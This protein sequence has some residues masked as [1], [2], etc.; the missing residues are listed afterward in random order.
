MLR[1]G[2]AGTKAPFSWQAWLIVG[3]ERKI[4][5]DTGFASVEKAR[6]WQIDGFRSVPQAIALL[7]LKP[8][9]ITD[10]VLT[11]AHWDHSGNL[12]PYERSRAWIQSQEYDWARSLTSAE[13]PSRSG[14]RLADVK[15]LERFDEAGRLR[16]VD[17]EAEVAPGVTLSRGGGHTRAIQWVTVRTGGPTGTVVLATDVAYVYES[18][19]RDMP[20]GATATPDLDRALYRKMLERASRPELAI[21]GHDPRVMERFP[22]VANGIVEI[23]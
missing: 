2:K 11:H 15:L 16:R 23:R 19:E 7:N 10:V 20:S 5:V 17:G 14:V 1:D 4:L 12:A 21:P 22:A 8:A 18:F 13:R 3:R 6:R 9:D